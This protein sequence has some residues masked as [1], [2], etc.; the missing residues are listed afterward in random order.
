M[1]FKMAII[2]GKKVKLFSL[3]ANIP[4]AKEIS[5]ASGIELSDLNLARFADGEIS[6]NMDD[7]VRGYDVY[8]VQPTSA[9]V[10]EH[11][12]ELFIMV[13]ALKRASSNSITVIMPYYG[14]SRQ[15][16][17]AKSRQP[18]TAK[19]VAD[20]LQTAGVDRVISIDLHAAQIQGF[21]D[22]PID[23]FPGAP[24]LSTYFKKK[25]L[26]DIVV[27]SPDHGGATRVRDFARR[28]KGS[29]IAIMDK[30]RPSA[31]KAEVLSIIGEVKDKNAILVDD[32]I[33]TGGSM[34]AAAKA[35]MAAG[36]KSVYAAATHP[37]FSNEALINIENCEHLKEVVVTN[38]IQLPPNTPSKVTQLSMGP[39]LG[40]AIL[41]LVKDESISQIFD[42]FGEEIESK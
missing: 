29:T 13:D 32:I 1:Y 39:L 19:L 2:G 8:V 4:L 10:N 42:R 5:A 24:L 38:T 40:Q 15:D 16:R 31:N 27:V 22:I 21:Y 17:K 41:H 14:Y 18:I 9:P 28:L 35:L 25:K 20:L 30:K 37:V 26:Q 34:V 33:D 23:N 12:M 11:Y 6:I 36:A 3:S 7:S